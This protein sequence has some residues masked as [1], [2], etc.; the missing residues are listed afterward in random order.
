MGQ[1]VAAFLQNVNT[2][3]S[4][5]T[6]SAVIQD[7][8]PAANATD[9]V[10]LTGAAGKTVTLTNVRISGT[11][12]AAASQDIYILKRSAGNTGGTSAAVVPTVHDSTDPAP[13]GAVVKYSA[14]PSALGAGTLLRGDRVSIP[15]LAGAN[16]TTQVWDFGDRAAKAPKLQN[17]SESIA[18]NWGGASV[19]AGT[20]LYITLEWTEE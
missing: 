6:Y 13:S 8:A 17:A 18:I 14:N 2:E 4:K 20:N 9:I 5:A 7:F 11:A 3:S 1:P 19:A 16:G 10:T 15:A 12:T